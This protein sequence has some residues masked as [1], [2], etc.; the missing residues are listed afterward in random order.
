[1]SSIRR[2][3][4]FINIREGRYYLSFSIGFPEKT[5]YAVSDNIMGPW[6][7]KGVINE[8]AGNCNTNHHAIFQFKGQWYFL[9][10]NGGLNTHGASYRRALCLDKLEYDKK[11]DIKRIQMT[12]EGIW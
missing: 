9:Y 12:T 10:H 2:L 1:M 7:Y 4:G 3:R 8:I 6:E 11:G 5:A